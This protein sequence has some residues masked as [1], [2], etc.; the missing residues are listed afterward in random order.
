MA[1]NYE[2][3]VSAID[4]ATGTINNIGKN[5]AT[6]SNQMTSAFSSLEKVAKIAGAAIGITGLTMALKD[7]LK[8]WGEQQKEIIQTA[9]VLKSTGGVAGMTAEAIEDLATSLQGTTPYADEVIQ[10]AEN[11]LLTFTSIGK[12]IF[13]DATRAVLDMS[14][15][16]GQDLSGTAIQVGKALQD[17]ILGVTALRRV[18]V[19]FNEQQQDLIRTMVESGR[20]LEA[21]KYILSE[22]SKEFG[23]S[24][25]AAAGTYLGRM[26]QLKNQIDNVKEAIGEALAPAIEMVAETLQNALGGALQFVTHH[27]IEF[28]TA[29][30]VVG[31]MFETVGIMAMGAANIV[32]GAFNSIK[33]GSLEPLK[34]AVNDTA[35]SWITAMARAQYRIYNLTAA[36]GRQEVSVVKLTNASIVTEADKKQ[37]ALEKELSQEEDDFRDSMNARTEDFH[38]SMADLIKG[39]RER[40]DQAKK[41]LKEEES[42]F[43]YTQ[44]EAAKVHKARV[45]D[46]K[47]QIK[48][49][50][51]TMVGDN[52]WR[53]I[54]LKATLAEEERSYKS[55][56]AYELIQHGKRVKGYK[57]TI[58]EEERILKKHSNDA[59]IVK[60]DLVEDDIDRLE[61]AFKLETEKLNKQHKVKVTEIKEKG[62]ELGGSEGNEYVGGL[63]R[64]I[65]AGVGD[66][67]N[68]ENPFV[69]GG[70]DMGRAFI[71][72]AKIG[73]RNS[74]QSM[75]EDFKESVKIVFSAEN[76]KNT[77]GPFFAAVFAG[78]WYAAGETFQTVIGPLLPGL[79]PI[80]ILVDLL[81]KHQ[82]GGTVAGRLGEP[83][84][85]LAHGGER[86]VPVQGGQGGGGGGGGV[87]LNVNIGTYAGSVTE[88]RR[89]A[90]E[91][92]RG[93][94]QLAKRNNQTVMEYLSA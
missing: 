59:N 89:L 55:T 19:N 8:S 5:V 14:Y 16:L 63:E 37:R 38:N 67:S 68:P 1:T 70:S 34:K 18:G 62:K 35:D 43:H 4:N 91:L 46:I 42:S 80:G 10:R 2:I 54:D 94:V 60:D 66:I 74:M 77:F 3:I 31:A 72:G 73:I 40:L 78:A 82:T 79:G 29:F 56:T 50:T 27:M 84:L 88:K 25:T 52:S 20:T 61:E 11:L 48:E 6:A 86:V 57:D 23:G 76:I 26:Q 36:G 39:H 7:S 92:Y 69:Q 24:A 9:T 83:Q 51:A 41:D 90:E 33:S 12:D 44:T 15:A 22:L 47:R 93:L 45:A 75:W 30:I 13:P 53:L 71:E 65:D 28:K 87:T 64:A 81:S 21:Q 49:E 32:V 17:P 85:I 58:T